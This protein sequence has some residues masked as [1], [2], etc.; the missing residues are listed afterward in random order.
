MPDIRDRELQALRTCREQLLQDFEA[1]I[2]QSTMAIQ[3]TDRNRCQRE[4]DDLIER[5]NQVE[6]RIKSLESESSGDA[7]NAAKSG[8]CSLSAG[9][10]PIGFG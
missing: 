7:A 1:A 8:N 6:D 5:I 10:L 4:A 2:K 3:A 9:K